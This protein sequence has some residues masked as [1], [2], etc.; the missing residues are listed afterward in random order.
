MI[1]EKESC[2]GCGLCTVICPKQ[3]IT[4][5]K[6]ELGTIRCRVDE[7]ACIHCGKCERMCPQNHTDD[8]HS[9]I[10][11]YAGWAVDASERATSSSGGIAAALYRAVLHK[12]GAVVGA[13]YENGEF[14]LKVTENEADI[15][16]FKG[17]KYVNCTSREIFGDVK[18]KIREGKPVL[19]IGTP[20]QVAA[21]RTYIGASDLL[22]TVDLVCH[23]TPPQAYFAEH[24]KSPAKENVATVNFRS[25][26]LYRLCIA[27]KDGR[28]HCIDS[29]VDEYYLAFIHGIT[30]SDGCY[31]CRYADTRRVSDITVGDFRGGDETVGKQEHVDRVSLLL[32]NT[33]RG[34][35]LLRETPSIRLVERDLAE[36]LSQNGQLSRPF[37]KSADRLKFEKLYPRL[38][39]DKTVHR[40]KIERIRRQ[41][42]LLTKLSNLKRN[43]KS[44]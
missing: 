28:E 5:E 42:C 30:F 26:G 9:V 23:G 32:C 7:G 36:A 43:L 29:G 18:E 41:N 19:F 40:L 37:P 12:G 38:G 6:S 4:L 13:C 16:Q 34:E 2:T 39:F 20:C 31:E 8:R 11:C 10:Q 24:F 22:Y 14:R 21:I 1:C 33:P 3:C 25:Q 35:Q 44:K 27:D 17:S 15:W